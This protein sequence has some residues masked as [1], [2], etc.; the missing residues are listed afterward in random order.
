MNRILITHPTYT[1][2]AEAVYDGTGRLLRFDLSNTN[3][4]PAVIRKF[5][6]V[7]PPH[8]DEVETAFKS[9]KA[10]VVIAEFDITLEDFKREYPY[11][12]NYHLLDDLWPRMK[13]TDQVLA[14]YSAIEYRKYCNREKKWYKP[15]IAATWINSREYLNDWKKC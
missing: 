12:R 6:D 15:R 10:T 1:G 8:F 5:K 13:K 7:V 3:M 2:E 11:S 4:I 9:T 14:Y